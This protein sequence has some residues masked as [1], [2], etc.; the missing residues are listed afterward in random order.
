MVHEEE[1]EEEKKIRERSSCQFE[2]LI[3]KFKNFKASRTK[4]HLNSSKTFFSIHSS[5]CSVPSTSCDF[6]LKD[7]NKCIIMHFNTISQRMIG[8]LVPCDTAMTKSCSRFSFRYKLPL[9]SRLRVHLLLSC[10]QHFLRLTSYSP[11]S[12][13]PQCPHAPSRPPTSKSAPSG[14]GSLWYLYLS[15]LALFFFLLFLFPI[16]LVLLFLHPAPSPAC[17]CLGAAV[18]K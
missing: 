12:Q 16:L 3:F 15:F 18:L 17:S 14:R 11:P 6:F 8:L 5:Q 10:A 7:Q 9:P 13:Y 1:E 2:R 4:L